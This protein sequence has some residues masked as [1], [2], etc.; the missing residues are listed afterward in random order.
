M[1]Y[2]LLI[3]AI[4]LS[5][6]MVIAATWLVGLWNNVI[7]WVNLVLSALVATSFFE[8]LAA[9][10][11]QNAPESS[12]LVDFVAIWGLFISTYVVLR[13][14]TE[15]L[16][17]YRLYFDYWTETIGRTVMSVAI[18]LTLFAFASFT[19][20]M[21]PMPIRGFWEQRFQ[22]SPEARSFGIGADRAWMSFV[23]AASLGSLAE[24]R[25]S[26]LLTPYELSSNSSVREFDPQH[27]MISK[28]HQRRRL[29]S[30]QENIQQVKTQ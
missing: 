16:S 24:S 20:H 5:L 21:A 13:V 7:S 6:G 22:P 4:L 29:L 9:Q 2:L 14:M 23:H 1:E 11:H 27:E 28:Y 25:E 12:Y 19:L 15:L 8:P 18:A 30:E 17:R 10:L 3:L 26:R